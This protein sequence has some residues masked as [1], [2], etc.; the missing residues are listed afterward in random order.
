MNNI[1]LKALRQGVGLTV[2]EASELMSV[3]KR[4]FQYWEAGNRAIPDD[5]MALFE[6]LRFSVTMLVELMQDDIAQY[7]RRHD[8]ISDDEGEVY[9]K[10]VLPF[11]VDFEHFKL[12][13]GCP[14]VQFWRVY[15]AVVSHLLV[16]GWLTHVDDAVEIPKNFIVNDWLANYTH[17]VTEKWIYDRDDKTW[18]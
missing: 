8:L 6:H 12:K 7:N 18:S 13:T 3:N 5:C 17:H 16:S 9:S 11:F 10:L 2:A 1:K 15:Q 4:S 14:L